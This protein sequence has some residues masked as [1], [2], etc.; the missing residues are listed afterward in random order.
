M[1]H[2]LSNSHFS[3]TRSGSQLNSNTVRTATMGLKGGRKFFICCDPLIA[4][5]TIQACAQDTTNPS[6]LASSLISS[7]WLA[8]PHHDSVS[9]GKKKKKAFMIS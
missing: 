5:M 4:Q 7:V 1:L 6:D 9:G 8:E 3:L 2:A